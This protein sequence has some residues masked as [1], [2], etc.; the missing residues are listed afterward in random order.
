MQKRRNMHTAVTM[1]LARPIPPPRP[2]QDKRTECL[3]LKA[4]GLI[5]QP[6]QQSYQRQTV[7][8]E[9]CLGSPAVGLHPPPKGLKEGGLSG[10]GKAR[11]CWY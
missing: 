7:P 8:V 2:L 1:V 3:R 10:W 6:V 11:G 9:G 4:L 5:A